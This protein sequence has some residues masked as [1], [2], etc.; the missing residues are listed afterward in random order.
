MMVRNKF[1]PQN[2]TSSGDSCVDFCFCHVCHGVMF[3][4]DSVPDDIANYVAVEQLSDDE[5]EPPL[6]SKDSA[7]S[8]ARFELQSANLCKYWLNLKNITI[9]PTF[10]K[11]KQKTC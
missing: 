7:T 5:P 10:R 4:W 8:I 11:K 9:Q 6:D 3:D 1:L 2:H